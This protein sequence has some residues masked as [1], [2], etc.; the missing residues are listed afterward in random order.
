MVCRGKEPAALLAAWERSFQEGKV[1]FLLNQ[2]AS[3]GVY[4]EDIIKNE[5]SNLV[6]VYSYSISC[7]KRLLM[8]QV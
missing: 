4:P 8:K 1:C 6:Q 7:K 5:H 2:Q 3:L